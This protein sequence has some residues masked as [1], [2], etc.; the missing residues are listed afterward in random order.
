MRLGR[1][2]FMVQKCLSS[3]DIWATAAED[4]TRTVR[5]WS[6]RDTPESW[7]TET[8]N[9]RCDWFDISISSTN[10][11]PSFVQLVNV[12]NELTFT[13]I[14]SETHSRPCEEVGGVRQIKQLLNASR[15]QTQEIQKHCFQMQ[16]TFRFSPAEPS[17]N[18]SVRFQRIRSHRHTSTERTAGGSSPGHTA[19]F[20]SSSQKQTE[21]LL[22]SVDHQSVC[23]S[24]D[25]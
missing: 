24:C 18:K 7:D 21:Q 5:F 20:M 4:G 2:P 23:F 11:R 9:Q 22:A 13:V 3:G 15:K 16:I 8:V 19:H 1:F 17:R 10:K 12:W 25:S 14:L 6:D